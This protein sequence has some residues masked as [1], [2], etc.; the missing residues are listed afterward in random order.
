VVSTSAAPSIHARLRPVEAAVLAERDAA[1]TRVDD[2]RARRPARR[3]PYYAAVNAAREHGLHAESATP[4][5][6]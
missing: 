3:D 1:R 5:V 6:A 4:P 2:Y